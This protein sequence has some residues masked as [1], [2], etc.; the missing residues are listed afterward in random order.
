MEAEVAIM[1]YGT[2][3][4]LES[5]EVTST[6]KWLSLGEFIGSIWL[7]QFLHFIFLICRIMTVYISVIL[8]K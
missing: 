4:F 8:R 2:K 3:D 1:Q 5:L 6:K 7:C